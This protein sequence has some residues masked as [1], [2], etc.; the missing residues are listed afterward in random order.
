[1]PFRWGLTGSFTSNGLEDVFGQC[2]VVDQTLLG[3]AKGA[4]LQ[5]YFICVNREYSEWEPRSGALEQVMETIRPATFVLEPGAYSDKLPELHVVKMRCDMPDRAPYEKMK[6][7]FLLE[8]GDDERIIA[9]NAAAMT[10]KLQQLACISEGTPVLTEH[11]WIPIEQIGVER[12]WDGSG[13]VAHGGVVCRGT[14][15]IVA[16]HG[17]NMTY[18][19]RVLTVKGWKSA[20]EVLHGDACERLD[21]A[22]VRLPDGSVSRWLQQRP[23]RPLEM[24]LFLRRRDNTGESIS[25][26]RHAVIRAEL[27]LQQRLRHTQDDGYAPVQCVEQYAPAMRPPTRQGLQELRREGNSSLRPMGAIREL[28]V[29]YVRE[30]RATFDSRQSGQRWSVQPRELPVGDVHDA[31]EQP[32]REHTD[33]NAGG[34]RNAIAG[35]ENPRYASADSARQA[36][37]LP[38]A[39]G[40]GVEYAR[41]FDILNCGPLNRFITLGA[42]SEL[43]TVHNC[44]WAYDTKTEV[45]DERGDLCTTRKAVW[46][47]SHK[48]DLLDEILEEN[49]HANTII[50]Y[51][52]KEELAELKRRYPQART[53]DDTDAINRWNAGEIELLLIHPKS[54]GHGLNLQFGGCKIIFLSLPWSLE[55]FEQTVGRLHRGGQTKDV[56]C[57]LLMCN[58]TVDERI[59]AALQDKRTISDLALEELKS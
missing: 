18:D 17:V 58:K 47:S 31:S 6:R 7:D 24:P 59:W 42:N 22:E 11:G 30:L 43:L 49:Q 4:F 19:H 46:F 34:Q 26:R 35:G 44:G 36:V 40:S 20:E 54:A 33:G 52:F 25:T 10:T 5:K 28:L 9:V 3:R 45:L 27:R 12:V 2:K 57:Y 14:K 13:W 55:L 1:V 32:A 15:Q 37:P 21:R 29:R 51:N 41:T 50:V 38:V 16:C 8:Y 23:L 39:V 48:F 53:I 56:W